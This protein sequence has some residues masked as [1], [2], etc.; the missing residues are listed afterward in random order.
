MKDHELHRL[1]EKLRPVAPD[2]ADSLWMT[3]V[4]DP[5]RK[6]DVA[7]VAQ[8]LCAEALGETYRQDNLFLEPPPQ[9]KSD[10]DYRLGWVTYGGRLT[11]RFGLR[12]ED[13]TQ[14]IAILGRSG[15]GKSNV[16]YL[17]VW[18]LLQKQ[19]PFMILDWRRNYRHL[20]T[21]PA[22]H[23]LLVLTAGSPKSLSFNP[24]RPPPRLTETQREAYLRDVVS[25][26]CTTYL[27]GHHLLSTR[28]VEYLML[29]GLQ[30]LRAG[31]LRTP[32]FNDLSGIIS[33]YKAKSREN[34]WKASA[35]NIL[36]KLN[37]GPIGSVFNSTDGFSLPDLLSRPVILELD[38]LGSQTD[39]A[40]FSKCLLLWLFYHRL[41]EGRSPSSKHVLIVEEAHHCFLRP[42]EG[43]QSLQ[44]LMLRQM[45]DL[46]QSIVLLDQNPSLLSV[47]ALG[48][49][50]TTI[51]LNL[52]HSDDVEAAGRALGLPKDKRDYIGRLA[53]GQA[54]VK[55][56]SRHP[57]PFL[58]QFP[59]FPAKKAENTPSRQP[60]RLGTHS[61]KPSI[62]EARQ[63]LDEAIRALRD[64]D[65]EEDRNRIGRRERELLLDVSEY[66]FSPVTERYDRLGWSAYTGT[67]IKQSLLEQG[68]LREQKLKVPE[69]SVTLLEVSDSGNVWLKQEG[70]E[71]RPFPKNATIEH[72]Y[73]KHRIAE[74]YRSRG[75]E[76]EEEVPIG[77][78]QAVDLVA[79]KDGQRIAIEVETG[80]SDEGSNREK[81]IRSDFSA[82]RTIRVGSSHKTFNAE[83]FRSNYEQSD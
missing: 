30:T 16:G 56:Q 66:P 59:L 11:S 24:L 64:S 6:T 74:D 69:G 82:V 41:A 31:G 55:V 62:E 83:L 77:G 2:L 48:N 58:V 8:A 67:K 25:T 60:G 33:S 70:V 80:K 17:L 57:K 35:R 12:D 49:T 51:C 50:A 10:G 40:A 63:A 61:L 71:V 14:H 42:R 13:L 46:G 19:K 38:S 34:D 32:A 43:G 75:Y 54:V 72:E 81:C 21:D 44:D 47:P 27:P 26:L 29:T 78:G 22:G 68:L 4:L 9:H 18:H 23:H 7:A 15:A 3:S 45:R 28:G 5:A 39:R 1:L 53:V 79:S 37:T 20:A 65:T 73:W 36:L 76:V 52:K